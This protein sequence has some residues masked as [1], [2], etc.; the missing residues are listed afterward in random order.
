[1][2]GPSETLRED[3]TASAFEPHVGEAFTLWRD[4]STVALTLDAAERMHGS[5]ASFVLTFRTPEPLGQGTYPVEH[6]DVGR[7]ALF[8]VPIAQDAQ[9]MTVEAVFNRTVR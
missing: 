7:M 9:G 5:D 6:P 2:S 4:A 8:L 1:M 3:L